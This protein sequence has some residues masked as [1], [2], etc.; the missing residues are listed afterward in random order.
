MCHNG[1]R[2]RRASARLPERVLN[3]PWVF[4]L[5]RSVIDPGQPRHLRRLLARVP[6]ASVLEVGCGV[7]SNCEMT[8]AAYTG[9]DLVP[10]YI[11]YARA[12]YGGPNR[13][14][15]VGDAFSLDPALGHHDVVSFIN[16]I[17]HLSDAE[18]RRCLAAARTVTP[19]FVLSVDIAAE[20]A[21]YIFHRVFAPL[22]RGSH[23]RT[24]AAQRTLLEEDGLRIEWEARYVTATGIYPRSALLGTFAPP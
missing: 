9:L 6:H 2:M 10:S 17:H 1:I 5:L 11:T 8:D 3:T 14:F 24:T 4:R 13:R 15:E 21:G 7:G 22:D 20:R 19:R 12:K 23:F 16:V 18:V